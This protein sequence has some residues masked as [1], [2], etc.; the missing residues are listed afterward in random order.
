MAYK[1]Q[2]V[3]ARWRNQACAQCLD[4]WRC[5]T[6]H[7]ARKRHLMHSIILRMKHQGILG[8]W[9]NW[10]QLVIEG[11]QDRREKERRDCVRARALGKLRNREMSNAYQ[12]WNQAVC[13]KKSITAKMKRVA[14]KW[15]NPT[16]VLC[17][18]EWKDL[19][20]RFLSFSVLL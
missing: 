13:E 1:V 12:R 11:K 17:F 5:F 2:K 15:G 19:T 16:F 7:E 18:S 6:V 9:A 3:V 20:V 10:L 4:A 14:M 8:A